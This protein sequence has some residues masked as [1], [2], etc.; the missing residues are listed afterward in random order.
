MNERHGGW[1]ANA[2]TQNLRRKFKA[3]GSGS[4]AT[5]R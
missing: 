5:R 1:D 2:C 4:D 3:E